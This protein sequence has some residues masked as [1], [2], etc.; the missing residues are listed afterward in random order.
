MGAAT[1]PLPNLCQ[2]GEFHSDASRH[3]LKSRLILNSLRSGGLSLDSQLSG[4][5]TRTIM[6]PPTRTKI[7]ERKTFVS[8]SI[9]RRRCLAVLDNSPANS[10]AD[11]VGVSYYCR[12]MKNGS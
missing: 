2:G 10:C 9:P 11:S 4:V 3:L 5:Q 12:A 8:A 7:T 1:P 6:N